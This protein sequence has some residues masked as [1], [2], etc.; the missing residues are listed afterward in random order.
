MP[1]MPN[2]L[3][4]EEITNHKKEKQFIIIQLSQNNKFYH[5]WYIFSDK[6]HSQFVCV[7]KLNV[8]FTWY[9]KIHF[10]MSTYFGRY[11]FQWSHIIFYYIFTEIYL[12]D[13]LYG[14]SLTQPYFKH[15]WEKQIACISRCFLNIFKYNGIDQERAHIV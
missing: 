15:C 12:W 13:L 2:P 1:G 9:T 10:H 14:F 4:S 3:L 11:Y 5:I 7:I 8:I 6:D